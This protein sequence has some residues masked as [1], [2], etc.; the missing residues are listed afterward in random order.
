VSILELYEV[1][2]LLFRK[3]SL[4]VGEPMSHFHVLFSPGDKVTKTI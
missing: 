1:M 3:G 4:L 2:K